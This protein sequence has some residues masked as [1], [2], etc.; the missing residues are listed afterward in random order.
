MGTVSGKINLAS[1]AR[2]LVVALVSVV[3]TDAGMLPSMLD[4]PPGSSY[5]QWDEPSV[6]KPEA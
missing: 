4:K 5:C 2:Y 1:L 3:A 6:T